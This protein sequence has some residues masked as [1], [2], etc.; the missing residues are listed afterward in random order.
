M[1]FSSLTKLTLVGCSLIAAAWYS[2]ADDKNKYT[3]WSE[4]LGGPE[5]THYS[6]LTQITTENVQNLQMAWEY[7]SGDTTGQ[8]QCNPIIVDGIVYGTTASVQVFALDAATGK[9]IWK[10]QDSKDPQ[11]FNS[12]RGVTYWE[13]GND[14]RIFF[15]AGQ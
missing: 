15:S 1:T 5:R 14:K 4:F 11:W 2:I 3:V 6:S 12:N 8:I 13:D 10:Y 7:H 9:E